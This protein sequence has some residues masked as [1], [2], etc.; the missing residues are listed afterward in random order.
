MK[1]GCNKGD[2]ENYTL[3]V[4]VTQHSSM[5]SS[6]TAC[7]IMVTIHQ[8]Q[9]STDYRF[10]QPMWRFCLVV[11]LFLAGIAIILDTVIGIFTLSIFS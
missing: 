3:V 8:S 4:R 10:G 6:L 9:Q 1:Q 7:G 11:T 2:K 5:N